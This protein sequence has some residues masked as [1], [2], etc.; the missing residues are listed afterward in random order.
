MPNG[1]NWNDKVS[2][3]LNRALVQNAVRFQAFNIFNGNFAMNAVPQA[4]KAQNNS[5]LSP[6]LDDFALNVLQQSSFNFDKRTFR[7]SLAG[8][9]DLKLLTKVFKL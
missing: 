4:F 6:N 2:R 8:Y 5:V 1:N 3:V 7:D 9:I